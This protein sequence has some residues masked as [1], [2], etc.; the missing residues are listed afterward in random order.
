MRHAQH[1]HRATNTLAVPARRRHPHPTRAAPAPADPPPPGTLLDVPPVDGEDS[2][3]AFA[4]LV[5]LAVAK[6]P[7]LAARTAAARVASPPRPPALAK[8]PWLRQRAPQGDRYSYLTTQM[9]TL[10][11]ATVCEEAQCPNIGEC[12]NGE[13]GTATVMILGDTCTRGC[14]FCAVNTASTP[15]PPDPNEPEATAAAVADWGVGYVVLTSVDRDDMPDGGADHFARTVR[16]IKQR[17]PKVLVECL[18]PDFQGDLAAVRMLASS[19]LDVFAHNV[20]TVERLQKRVRD[21]R[22]G[23]RQSLDVLAAAKSTGVYTKSSIMLGLGETD[24]EIE[25]TLKDLKAAGVDIVTF[26]QYLQPTPRHLTVEE[27]VTPA[28][29]DHWRDYGQDVVGFRYVA[30]GPLVR[31]SYKAGEFF[32]EA[33]IR[34]DKL[35]AEKAEKA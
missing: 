20:E 2:E 17:N 27:Y 6:D 4:E 33:M 26:G 29:F 30:S 31:S 1:T 11:L 23:Y 35:D 3:D 7:T 18:T 8:P 34:G 19:G 22:A 14:R 21:P 12:W 13:T 24:A 32:V 25:A 9:R 16:G 5:R 28:K 15:A 10:S